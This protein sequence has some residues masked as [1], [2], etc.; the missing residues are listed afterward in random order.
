M[1]H[2]A[3]ESLWKRPR[4]LHHMMQRADHLHNTGI[5]NTCRERERERERYLFPLTGFSSSSCY[6]RAQVRQSSAQYPAITSRSHAAAARHGMQLIPLQGPGGAHRND[7]HRMNLSAGLRDRQTDRQTDIQGAFS[8]NLPRISSH[9][10]KNNLSP[11][12]HHVKDLR[13][14]LW[15]TLSH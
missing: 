7:H 1:K 13:M 14:R 12:W 15:V 11:T 10:S 8:L 3:T 6:S 4:H 2:C 5:S 9:S